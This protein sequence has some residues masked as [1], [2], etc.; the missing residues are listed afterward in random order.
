[1]GAIDSDVRTRDEP[2][3][4]VEPA[5]VPPMGTSTQLVSPPATPQNSWEAQT[6]GKALGK[7]VNTPQETLDQQEIASTQQ[8][9]SQSQGNAFVG[10]DPLQSQDSRSLQQCTPYHL[11]DCNS[12][13]QELLQFQSQNN[14]P[15]RHDPSQLP[16]NIFFQQFPSQFQDNAFSGLDSPQPQ[17]NKSF[18]HYTFP[19]QDDESFLQESLQF[20]DNSFLLPHSLQFQDNHFSEQL[21]PQSLHTTS[22]PISH[23]QPNLY[24]PP[25]HHPQPGLNLLATQPQ[26]HSGPSNFDMTASNGPTSFLAANEMFVD[27]LMDFPMSG[28][29]T[30]DASLSPALA[31]RYGFQSSSRQ[32]AFDTQTSLLATNSSTDDDLAGLGRSNVY[33][34][35]FELP[36]ANA[37]RRLMKVLNLRNPHDA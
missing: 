20:Q 32:H 19:L 21:F 24:D 6:D 14:T 30:P 11:Q 12:F 5:S 16:N 3:S 15:F 1:M 37:H 17:G 23:S 31:M 8:T 22:Q 7:D 36:T 9:S 27:E 33:L 35:A 10:L 18:Q 28:L 29:R 25:K 26:V 2:I 34:D 4:P 13:Q